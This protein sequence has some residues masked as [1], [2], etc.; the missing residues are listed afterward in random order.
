MRE[1][2]SPKLLP[3]GIC[4][5]NIYFCLYIWLKIIILKSSLVVINTKLYFAL[6]PLSV[7]FPHFWPT[8]SLLLKGSRFLTGDTVQYNFN[9]FLRCDSS[10]VL[11]TED[12]TLFTT[13]LPLN[14]ELLWTYSCLFFDTVSTVCIGQPQ[15]NT[16]TLWVI[17]CVSPSCC[18][19]SSDS[20][21]WSPCVWRLCCCIWHQ[22]NRLIWYIVI[23][24]CN[25]SAT[26]FR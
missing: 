12:F 18:L 20:E 19:N 5:L 21:A 9:N 24:R 6:F 22:D 26:M 1:H 16:I 11:N 2:N 3:Y 10:T 14:Y 25:W 13:I 17:L 4:F 15:H 23:I 8:C 7:W